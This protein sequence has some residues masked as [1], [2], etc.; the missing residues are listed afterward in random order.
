MSGVGFDDSVTDRLEGSNDVVGGLVIKKAPSKHVFRTPQESM[1]GLQKLAEEKRKRKEEL[2]REE[3]VKKTKLTSANT[4][5]WEG[6]SSNESQGRLNSEST[7]EY[8]PKSR[9]YRSHL[10]ETPSH[11][12]GVNEEAREKQLRRLERDRDGRRGGVYAESRTRDWDKEER[13]TRDRYSDGLKESKYS[14][15]NRRK[16]SDRGDRLEQR[17]RDWRSERSR[18]KEPR[19]QRSEWEETPGR[20]SRRGDG[21]GY[22][23]RLKSEGTVKASYCFIYCR[24]GSPFI[25]QLPKANLSEPRKTLMLNCQIK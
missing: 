18:G 4:K 20:S 19:S 8:K 17:S 23:P 24:S 5:E 16:Y 12:G 3:E 25:V 1:L 11:T 7:R 22:T 10:V 21:E 15:S 2:E 14:D 13:R 6:N 9:H